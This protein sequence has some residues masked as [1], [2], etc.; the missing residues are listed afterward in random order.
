MGR[1]AR[2]LF[3]FCMG[4]VLGREREVGF[5]FEVVCVVGDGVLF[6]G[7]I[8]AWLPTLLP[9]FLCGLGLLIR[10]SRGFM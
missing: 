8:C 9:M 7:S 4:T 3:A 6:L 10:R 1:E 5:G 2:K